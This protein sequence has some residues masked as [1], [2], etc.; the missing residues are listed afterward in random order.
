MHLSSI[1]LSVKTPGGVLK[2]WCK[3]NIKKTGPQRYRME[4]PLRIS[5][6]SSALSAL[7]RFF[8]TL[9]PLSFFAENAERQPSFCIGTTKS[10]HY[11]TLK[12]MVNNPP[13]GLFT[14]HI[15]SED[16]SGRCIINR[17]DPDSSLCSRPRQNPARISHRNPHM[18][19]LRR[20]HEAPSL[21]QIRDQRGCRST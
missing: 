18:H 9:R 20:G 5:A 10:G 14:N 3:K 15:V 7:N 6:S 13:N 16:Q 19:R 8:L 2:V 21:S 1:I 4:R 17:S 11:Q 12:K